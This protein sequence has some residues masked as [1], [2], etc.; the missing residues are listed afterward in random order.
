MKGHPM[1]LACLVMMASCA[2]PKRPPPP[3]RQP[4]TTNGQKYKEE[5]I[6]VPLKKGAPVHTDRSQGNA[7]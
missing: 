4:K 5:A 7:P 1:L 6:P 3:P 2:T